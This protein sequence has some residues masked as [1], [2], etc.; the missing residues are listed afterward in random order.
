M[1]E[2][3]H[4]QVSQDESEPEPEAP[5]AA[6]PAVQAQGLDEVLDG[7]DEVLEVNALTF[8]QSFRQQGGQ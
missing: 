7:I 2:R 4:A 1:S 3:I 8:V 5:P 6:P